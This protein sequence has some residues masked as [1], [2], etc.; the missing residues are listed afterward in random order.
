M[1]RLWL[2]LTIVLGSSLAFAGFAQLAP[3]PSDT[4]FDQAVE[5]KTAAGGESLQVM[6]AALARSIN[7]TAVVDDVPDKTITYDI[8]DPKPFRQVWNIVLSLNDLDYLLLEND[9]V[10]VG[11]PASVAKLRKQ[12]SPSAQTPVGEAAM[13]EIVQRFYRVSSDVNEV[14]SFLEQ[15]L[16]EV[17]INIFETLNIISARGTQAQQDE[18]AA[19]LSQIDRTIEAVPLEQRVYTLSNAKAADL[20]QVLEASNIQ[21]VA[22]VADVQDG[23]VNQPQLNQQQK[24]FTVTADERTNSLIVTATAAVQARIA[25]LIPQLDVPVP[26]VNVQ[27]RIQE[28]TTTAAQQ[29]GIN[30]NAGLGSFATTILD[31]GLNFI[32]DAQKAISGLNIGA[33]LDTLERQGLSR[34]VDDSNLTVLNNGKAQIQ[35]GGTIFISIPGANDNIERTIPYGVQIDV[36]PQISADG[37]VIL[38]VDAKVE[39][40]LSETADPSFLELSTR[41][42]SSTVSLSPGQTIVL[43]GLLQN[44]FT[45]TTNRVPVLG[46]I[47]LIGSLFSSTTVEESNTEL[48]L[49]IN[50]MVIE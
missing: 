25:E 23:Q 34:R 38:A 27:V 19:I 44:S 31:G 16:P 5:F 35:S 28:I 9:V 4:I 3:L 22:G 49:I 11:T 20:A 24:E 29:L 14:A 36:Q 42:V 21:N 26:Q 37:R 15:E 13:S 18:V 45:D 32:F 48:L 40:V 17:S 12:P 8:G 7:L 43:G 1:K 47:P 33:V 6:V 2:Y 39:D 46:S 50:A 30:L 41:K 10:V